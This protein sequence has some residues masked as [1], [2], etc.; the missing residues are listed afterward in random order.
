MV[1]ISRQVIKENGY[2][3]VISVVPK[4]STEM[5]EEDMEG[6]RANILVTEVFDTDLIGEGGILTFVH[7]HKHLLQ[8]SS[9][10]L[11]YTGC[12]S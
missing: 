5:T 10:V 1:K 7:A 6:G 8:V 2:S 9:A 12:C 11:K 3:G 4:R